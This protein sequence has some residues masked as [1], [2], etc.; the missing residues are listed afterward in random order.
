LARVTDSS[1]PLA[2]SLDS[3]DVALVVQDGAVRRANQATLQSWV[4]GGGS[5]DLGFKFSFGDNLNATSADE[6]K[7]EADA[8]THWWNNEADLS[9]QLGYNYTYNQHQVV[10]VYDRGQTIELNVWLAGDVAYGL[11]SKFLDDLAIMVRT[12]SRT[13]I[14]G[15]GTPPTT[16]VGEP[17]MYVNL[18][19][20][21]DETYPPGHSIEDEYAAQY[22]LAVDVCH[23]A[24]P[25]AKVGLGMSAYSWIGGLYDMSPWRECLLASD[26]VG[27][28]SMFASSAW[29]SGAET[30]IRML[31]HL[32]TYSTPERPL[33]LSH[34]TIW[35]EVGDTA[36]EVDAANV[37]FMDTI[38]GARATI[39]NWVWWSFKYEP[40]MDPALE[41]PPYLRALDLVRT[42]G[43][44]SS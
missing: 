36:A 9:W 4:G 43:D 12:F 33:H 11:S 34:Q 44:R 17:E 6:L 23:A 1:Y 30:T 27:G 21:I 19:S 8:V 22:L 25:N 26:W 18:F 31:Q 29:E 20:E 16:N 32:S 3:D 40:F 39:P 10:E 5:S 7:W 42:Y 37:N 28:Q 13:I 24:N 2:D 14:T 38:W 15:D 41:R 35:E